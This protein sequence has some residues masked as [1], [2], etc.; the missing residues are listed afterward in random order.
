MNLH[1]LTPSNDLFHSVCFGGRRILIKK[2]AIFQ[3]IEI[4]RKI[5]EVKFKN[6]YKMFFLILNKK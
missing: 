4:V 6:K 1:T 2:K 5:T 3:C